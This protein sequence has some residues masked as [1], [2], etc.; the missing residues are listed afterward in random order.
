MNRV[1]NHI[2][3]LS[4]RTKLLFVGLS[5]LAL[6]AGSV[7][8]AQPANA[9]GCTS[10]TLRYGAGGRCV[11][12]EQTMLNT[13]SSYYGNLHYAV[14]PV[15]SQIGVDGSYGPQTTSRVRVFQQISGLAVDGITGPQTWSALCRDISYGVNSSAWAPGVAAAR[16]AG[17]F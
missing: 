6:V 13:L 4:K 3:N 1:Y 10:V 2:V 14:S 5:A 7:G 8:I 17:C 16:D 11:S 9:A 12:D 15:G